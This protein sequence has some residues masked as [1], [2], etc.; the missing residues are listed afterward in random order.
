MAGKNP[1]GRTVEQSTPHATY[2]SLDGSWEWLVLKTY[3]R[4]DME[5]QHSR[6]FCAVM[7]PFLFG[8]HELGDG[9]ANDVRMHGILVPEES[10]PE[11]VDAYHED[12]PM[13]VFYHNE[14][15]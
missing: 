2:R 1:F 13:T 3:Q 6:W 15:L 8:S 9:Y 11:W 7:S 10:T 4:P 14:H 12:V 5:G